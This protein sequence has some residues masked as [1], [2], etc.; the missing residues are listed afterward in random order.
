MKFLNVL[1]TALIT[2]SAG[3]IFVKPAAPKQ[4]P[5]FK[6]PEGFTGAE[7][8]E[9][10]RKNGLLKEKLVGRSPDTGGWPCSRANQK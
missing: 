1:F 5:G 3:Q 8:L 4:L 7:G 10:F 6:G 9:K 2:F